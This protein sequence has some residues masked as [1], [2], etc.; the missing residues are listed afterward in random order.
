MANLIV[1]QRL[2]PKA[3]NIGTEEEIIEVVPV[4]APIQEPVHAPS[5][6]APNVEPAKE[7]V[8]V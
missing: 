2:A 1:D 8:P 5:E 7:P 3:A 6:P 4:T